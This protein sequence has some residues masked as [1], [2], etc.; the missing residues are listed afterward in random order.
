MTEQAATYQYNPLEM[1]PG[2]GAATFN[3]NR[4]TLLVDPKQIETWEL[5]VLESGKITA[6]MLIFARYLCRNGQPVSPGLPTDPIDELPKGELARIKD[7][8]AHKLLK[9]MKIGDLQAA[10][11]SFMEQAEAGF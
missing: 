7:S 4:P 3:D 2:N 6:C 8:E 11:R 9:R 10:I 1:A 5:M